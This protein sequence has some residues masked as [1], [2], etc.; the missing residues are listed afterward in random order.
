MRQL[1]II[2]IGRAA[3]FLLALIAMRVATTLLAP[4]EMGR[5]SLVMTTTAFFALLLINP[6]GMF[7]NRRL[8]A[9]Q[10]NGT[11]RP[12]LSHYWCYL[13]VAAVLSA[14]TLGLLR[15]AGAVGI[16]MSAS[17][18]LILVCGSLVFNTM[19]QTVIPSL[20]LLGYSGWFVSLTLATVLAGFTCATLLSWLI[21]PSAEYW[22]LGMLLGQ[23]ML[24]IIGVRIFFRMVSPVGK[25][26]VSTGI[27]TKH[28]GV[29]F[30]FAWPVAVAAGLSWAQG[31]GY[32]YWVEGTLGLAPLGL[33]VAGYGISAGLIAGFESVL[34]TYFQPRLYR[35]VSREGAAT[36]TTKGTNA[37]REY[38]AAI[39]PPLLLTVAFIVALAPE[40]TQLF[41]GDKFQ[42]AVDFVVW[43][44]LAEMGRV[45][46]SIYSLVAHAHMQTRWLI[47]PNLVGASLSIVLCIA[48]I[49]VFG[50][51]G[52]GAGLTLSG[53]AAVL[54]MRISLGEKASGGIRVISMAVA[55]GCAFA[56]LAATKGARYLSNSAEWWSSIAI[57]AL[58]GIL[59]MGMLYLLVRENLQ[60]KGAA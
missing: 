21:H 51:H 29:L 23:T 41:L 50:I 26:A 48:L 1:R 59:Y 17:W 34:I 9:W 38:S 55:A 27:Q 11:L 58:I 40:L 10:A 4:D 7:I 15:M 30:R 25:V 56:L 43:G 39:I 16:G 37:W 35:D 36:G 19:N 8:H 57:V 24:A 32:R 28:W 31:Q 3:Q 6:V 47:V 45:L 49:P 46:I 54:A 60:D 53:L 12:Y 14:I 5:V 2:V 20:N 44:A 33:F 18:L 22:L 42:S 13:I 52:V